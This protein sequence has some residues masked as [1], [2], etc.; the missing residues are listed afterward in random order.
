MMF[1]AGVFMAISQQ[2]MLRSP[3]GSATPVR[4]VCSLDAFPAEPMRL[5]STY[6]GDPSMVNSLSSQKPVTTVWSKE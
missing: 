4:I 2:Q 6:S 5:V 1:P 3:F